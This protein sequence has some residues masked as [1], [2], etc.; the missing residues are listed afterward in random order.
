MSR[1]LLRTLCTV[2]ALA[3]LVA[4]G[5]GISGVAAAAPAPPSPASSAPASGG[6]APVPS[7]LG[8]LDASNG[9][10]GIQRGTVPAASTPDMSQIPLARQLPMI[11]ITPLPTQSA[12]PDEDAADGT[13]DDTADDSS[14]ADSSSADS[15]SADSTAADDAA[16]SQ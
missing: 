13:T 7:L 11:G 6:P 5:V 1:Q 16:A 14:S 4:C 2:A 9:L 8:P 3:G 15:S 10:L 12:E